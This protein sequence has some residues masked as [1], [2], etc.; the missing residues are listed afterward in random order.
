MYIMSNNN[1]CSQ[2]CNSKKHSTRLCFRNLLD[3]ILIVS[4]KYANNTSLCYC[5]LWWFHE[6]NVHS[7]SIWISVYPTQNNIMLIKIH[8]RISFLYE[9]FFNH[10]FVG[11]IMTDSN[12]Q[13]GIIHKDLIGLSRKCWNP[14]DTI[15]TAIE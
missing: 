3:R 8:K 11:Y 15:P 1:T 2:K 13:T 14:P 6:V 9:M 12:R 5:V 7:G 10:S 4:N